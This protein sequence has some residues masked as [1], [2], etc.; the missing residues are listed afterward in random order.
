VNLNLFNMNKKVSKVRKPMA[1]NRYVSRRWS[2]EEKYCLKRYL[3]SG[4]DWVFPGYKA[5][6]MRVNNEFKNNRSAAA[7]R[8]MDYRMCNGG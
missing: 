6:A 5:A 7:C 3:D 1:Q 4:W 2:E 8:A